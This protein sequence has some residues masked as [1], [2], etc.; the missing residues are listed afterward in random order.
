MYYLILSL[1]RKKKEKEKERKKKQLEKWLRE[2]EE[3]ILLSERT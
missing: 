1:K 3:P 2:R